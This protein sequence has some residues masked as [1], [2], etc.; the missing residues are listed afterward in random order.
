[1]IIH[2]N[3]GIV[4]LT[5]DLDDINEVSVHQSSSGVNKNPCTTITFKCRDGI[6]TIS[7]ISDYDKKLHHLLEEFFKE[8]SFKGIFGRDRLVRTG[9]NIEND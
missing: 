3:T 6:L 5:T 2:L 7:S 4:Q 8:P 9:A 1:M